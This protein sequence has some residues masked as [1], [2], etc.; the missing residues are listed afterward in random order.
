[1]LS[2]SR[3][4]HLQ[5]FTRGMIV[6]YPYAQLAALYT[7]SL[8]DANQGGDSS[9]PVC[10]VSCTVHLQLFTRGDDSSL[11][12]CSVSCTVHLQ[13]FTNIDIL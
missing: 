12:V 5:L 7:Y 4:V 3:T 8:L 2:V 11:P 1:M 10:S 13:L 9:L 6:L